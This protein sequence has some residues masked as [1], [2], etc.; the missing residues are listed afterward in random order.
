[1]KKTKRKLTN[2]SLTTKPLTHAMINLAEEFGLWK[3]DI[4]KSSKKTLT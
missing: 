4:L 3:T 1:M 2:P